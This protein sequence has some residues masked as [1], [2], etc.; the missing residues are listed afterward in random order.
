MQTVDWTKF[1]TLPG[2]VNINF[3]KL[4]RSVIQRHYSQYGNFRALSNQPGIEFDLQLTAPSDLGDA[5]RWY[6]WQ[7]K[8]YGIESGKSIGAKRKAD[9]EDGIRKTEKY[10][11]EVTDWVLWTKHPLTKDDHKWFTAIS[12]QMRLAAKSTAELDDLLCGPAEILRRTYF[13]ELALTP[14][15]LDEWQQASLA[16]LGER[17]QPDLHQI[18]E[19]E[20]AIRLALFSPNEWAPLLEIAQELADLGQI[21]IPNNP[22]LPAV[23]T[24]GLTKLSEL[25]TSW[26]RLLKNLEDAVRNGAYDL[27]SGYF[28]SA[29]PIDEKW[30]T[31]VRQLQMQNLPVTLYVHNLIAELHRAW[32][33]VDKMKESQC[34][35]IIAVTGDAGYGKTDLAASLT[36]K[37]ENRP[38]GIL[39]HGGRLGA[40]ENLDSLAQH[41][42]LNGDSIQTFQ[43]LLESVDAAGRRSNTRLPIVI[44]GLNE[45]EDPRL[46]R[47]LL[48]ALKVILP[49]YPYILIICT[50]RTE[51]AEEALPE[52][53]EQI[54]AGDFG[55]NFDVAL[56]QYFQYYRIDA[57]DAVLP[58]ALLRTPLYLRIFCEVTNPERAIDVDVGSIPHSL[59][60]LFLGYIEQ[61]TARVDKLSSHTYRLNKAEVHAAL[62]EIGNELWT[63]G[64]RSF[65]A[66]DIRI[67]LNDYSRPWDSSIL[68]ALETAGVLTKQPRSTEG[69]TRYALLYDA[70]AGHII[71]KAILSEMSSKSIPTWI[72][73][74]EILKKLFGPI[75][76]K[77]TLAKDI[78]RGLVGLVPRG[79]TKSQLWCMLPDSFQQEA[80]F[81]TAFID[82]ELLDSSTVL[83]LE[84]LLIHPAGKGMELFDHLK[85][86]RA[87]ISHPLNVKF[88]DRVLRSLSLPNRDLIWTEWVRERKQEILEDLEYTEDHWRSF[89]SKGEDHL[90]AQWTMWILTSNCPILRDHATR[91]L[92]QF[93]CGDPKHLFQLT[94]DS[95]SIND[96]YISERMLAA[97]YGVAM[98]Y[99]SGADEVRT[100]FDLP[101]FA[102]NLVELMFLPSAQFST[103]HALAR[104]YALGIIELARKMDPECISKDNLPYLLPPFPHLPSKFPNPSE[105][106][107]VDSENEDGAIR[108]DFGNYT[109]GGLIAGRRNY[110]F[111]NP[112]Y[113]NVRKQ[114]EFRITELGFSQERFEEIDRL[115][116]MRD[117]S[118]RP[119]NR[120][121]TERYGKKYSWISF[122]EMYGQMSDRNELPEYKQ[123]NRPSDVD[124]DPSFPNPAR[125]FKP[126]IPEI[127]EA[128][129]VTPIDWLAD[130]PQ[131]S[132]DCLLTSEV[133]DEHPG[134]WVLL[135]GTVAQSTEVGA[136]AI[137]SFLRGFLVSNTV[138]EEVLENFRKLDYSDALSLPNPMEGYYVFSGEIP[139]S[140]HCIPE[141][142]A[143]SG[144]ALADERPAFDFFKLGEWQEGVLVENPS[145]VFCWEAYHSTLNQAGNVMFPAPAL[146]EQLQLNIRVGEWDFYDLTDGISGI[147]RETGHS[148]NDQCKLLYLR[149]DL[150]RTYLEKNNKTLIWLISGER[151][152]SDNSENMSESQLEVFQ[153]DKQQYK[154][155]IRW[156]GKVSPP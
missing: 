36:Q 100:K 33:A 42:V 55:M 115:I 22:T 41:L 136:R 28:E 38:A 18:S 52:H 11:P 97:S 72:S 155:G 90:R 59:T 149:A 147:Y 78:V 8:W 47:E 62:N 94:I 58:V 96:P 148:E 138:V 17:W 45:S 133:V 27:L 104:D 92:Y 23:Q 66:N 35:R 19:A 53:T 34:K 154:I 48:A 64:E 32:L 124:L 79:D 89:S 152:H 56:Q 50:L 69:V 135:N 151:E 145:A 129:P 68:R 14:Q 6:G 95:L 26:A 71:A 116:K 156:D 76:E 43:A 39:I 132:Y 153:L 82:S 113:I 37:D 98:T 81:E 31:L 131:P 110:D 120:V 111:E 3:E 20:R 15:T 127:F 142:R 109:I 128:A 105:I 10:F 2:S 77:H 85:T 30:R 122:F 117:M 101:V 13:G 46:W 25:A 150:M 9:I 70:L 1:E 4:C 40:R 108:M 24:E 130:G 106:K 88:V 7:C 146:C 5:P 49:Q 112:A 12:T 99:W 103:S 143:T 144:E 125:I 21:I 51:F 107:K 75:G 84:G 80:L 141:L 57:R 139:W 102:R 137:F 74:P 54:G 119:G 61:V 73:E 67:K 126:H 29:T 63:S 93:G 91:A 118:G 86:L 44:D 87:A 83:A 140:R 60:S 114:I 65:S 123:G 16:T 134:P 121:H